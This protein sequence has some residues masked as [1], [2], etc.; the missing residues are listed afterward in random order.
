[1]PPSLLLVALSSGFLGALPG[2][3]LDASLPGKIVPPG[4]GSTRRG[5]SPVNLINNAQ[6]R[7]IGVESAR[8]S[9]QDAR[10]NWWCDSVELM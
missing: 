9:E 5:L 1:M 7:R 10:P 8:H 3:C 2:G 6:A 4:G